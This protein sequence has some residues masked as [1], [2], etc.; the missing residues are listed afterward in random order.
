MARKCTVEDALKAVRDVDEYE[1]EQRNRRW[2]RRF[3]EENQIEL[4]E[5][6]RQERKNQLQ[7]EAAQEEEDFSRWEEENA[8]MW[9]DQAE[10]APVEPLFEEAPRGVPMNLD[11]SIQVLP[12]E[13]KEVILKHFIAERFQA[14]KKMGWDEVNRAILIRNALAKRRDMGW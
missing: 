8:R 7:R 14:R 2:E 4:N 5:A 11:R 9:E 1:A 6:V 12:P 10:T 3:E 13:I